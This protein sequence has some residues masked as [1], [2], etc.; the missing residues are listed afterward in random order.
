MSAFFAIM[1]RPLGVANAYRNQPIRWLIP[2]ISPATSLT[3]RQSQL[4][5]FHTTSPTRGRT[6]LRMGTLD[7]P[8]V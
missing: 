1:P 6:P 4:I 5:T 8:D 7:P 2:G 3:F